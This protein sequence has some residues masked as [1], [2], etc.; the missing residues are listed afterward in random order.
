MHA[1]GKR[2]GISAHVSRHLHTF[3]A[4]TVSHSLDYW[5]VGRASFGRKIDPHRA[6]TCHG[7]EG[8]RWSVTVSLNGNLSSDN[9][10]QI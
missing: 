9:A 2:R 10:I 4:A 8:L 6:R 5:R 7:E 3:A 1:K